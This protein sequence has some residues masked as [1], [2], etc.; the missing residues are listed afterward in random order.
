MGTTGSGRLH[1]YSDREGG[2]GDEC[3]KRIQEIL[4]D[5]ERCDYF[6]SH[7]ELPAGGLSIS[8]VA[9]QRIEAQ[10]AEGETIGYLPTKYNYVADCIKRGYS[11][12]GVVSTSVS[13]PLVRVGIMITP[14]SPDEG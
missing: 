1:E 4:E 5:V 13:E 11:Y 14:K 6:D 9:S 12:T 7:G 10:T 2:S 3:S 8:L